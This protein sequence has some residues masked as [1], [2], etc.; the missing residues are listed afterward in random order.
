ME[1][2]TADGVL[3]RKK[4]KDKVVVDLLALEALKTPAELGNLLQ[5]GLDDDGQLFCSNC[6]TSP[7]S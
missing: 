1:V 2:S 4:L 3:E 5:F 7:L 6:W